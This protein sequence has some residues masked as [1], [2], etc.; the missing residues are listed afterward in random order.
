M[1][2]DYQVAYPSEFSSF[3]LDGTQG[4]HHFQSDELLGNVFP[5]AV[6][7]NVESYSPA[8]SSTDSLGVG[9]LQTRSKAATLLFCTF[10]LSSGTVMYR[11]TTILLFTVRHDIGSGSFWESGVKK[12]ATVLPVE[13]GL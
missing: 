2:V 10:R 3:T 11:P 12:L 6:E 1:G 5:E 8:V 4:C 9:G 7:V 13:K